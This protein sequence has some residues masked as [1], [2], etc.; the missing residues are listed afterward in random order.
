[1]EDA[2]SVKKLSILLKYSIL[3]R[4]LV[5]HFMHGGIRSLVKIE[6]LGKITNFLTDSA[7]STLH[8]HKVENAE[9]S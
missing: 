4:L 2:E 9:S 3:T 5:F 1:V 8:P 6:Y 7:F